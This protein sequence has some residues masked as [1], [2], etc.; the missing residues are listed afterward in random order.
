MTAVQ[1]TQMTQRSQPSNQVV[2]LMS[3]YSIQ[4]WR[5]ELRAH[6]DIKDRSYHRKTYPKCFLGSDAVSVLMQLT[7]LDK[8][9]GSQVESRENMI[10]LGNQ[11]IKAKVFHHVC[12]EHGLEDKA[13]FYSLSAE[14]E[15]QEVVMRMSVG[16]ASIGQK[17]RHAAQTLNPKESV[18][19]AN[20]LLESRQ[21]DRQSR[22]GPNRESIPE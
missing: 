10:E 15:E 3:L 7:G 21:S 6:L 13:L 18:H 5:T 12:R 2:E 16:G 14:E 1:L 19:T 11:L 22:Q 4:E 20:P 17:E 8:Q 9:A